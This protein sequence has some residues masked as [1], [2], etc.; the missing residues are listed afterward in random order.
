MSRS[1]ENNVTLSTLFKFGKGDDITP[2]LIQIGDL[3]ITSQKDKDIIHLTFSDFSDGLSRI[4]KNH[5][6]RS[7]HDKRIIR[8]E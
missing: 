3:T 2:H 5:N 7:L 6:L 1:R 4:K 8:T